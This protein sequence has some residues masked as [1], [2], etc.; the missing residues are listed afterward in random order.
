MAKPTA[1]K[2]AIDPRMV[3]AFH[4]PSVKT[5]ANAPQ[6]MESSFL[7]AARRTNAKR[8]NPM[9]ATRNTMTAGA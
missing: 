6:A 9:I 4:I 5:M 8:I 3:V 7:P 1:T 2:L